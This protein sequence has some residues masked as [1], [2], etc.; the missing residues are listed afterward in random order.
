MRLELLVSS[1]KYLTSIFTVKFSILQK[2]RNEYE[3]KS[4]RIPEL[5]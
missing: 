2:K 4:C 5:S 3:S 1:Q